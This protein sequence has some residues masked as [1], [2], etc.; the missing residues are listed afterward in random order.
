VAIHEGE[1]AMLRDGKTLWKAAG[2]DLRSG[3]RLEDGTLRGHSQASIGAI[4]D[5]DA[6]V[7]RQVAAPLSPAA[8]A[9]RLTPVTG[10]RASAG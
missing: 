9:V 2:I 5:G 3:I 8:D 4:S 6:L 7:L 10:K 1:L